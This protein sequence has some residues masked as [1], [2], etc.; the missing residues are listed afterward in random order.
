MNIDT[1]T[2]IAIFV[3]GLVL[4][5]LVARLLFNDLRVR[6]NFEM[7]K[8]MIQFIIVF[9]ST[10]ICLI[11]LSTIFFKK[12]VVNPIENK[13]ETDYIL[14]KLYD[15]SLVANELK[16][17]SI[18]KIVLK[19]YRVYCNEDIDS[20]LPFHTFPMEKYYTYL[21][22]SK[23][24]FIERTKYEW[25]HHDFYDCNISREN[26]EIKSSN[27]TTYVSILVSQNQNE[28]IYTKIKLN[29]EFKIFWVGNTITTNY[30]TND[31][32]KPKEIHQ[33][34]RTPTN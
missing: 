6:V 18:F 4:S 29:K 15:K 19:Y 8:K 5:S 34:V 14:K 1:L 12:T 11:S 17:D 13:K 10:A 3:I 7:N 20:L 32:L 26:T 23:V 31:S 9:I 33:A 25:R 24:R 16:K 27:D 28:S 22:V 2:Y 21:S 30:Y